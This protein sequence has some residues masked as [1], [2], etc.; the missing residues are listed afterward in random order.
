[1]SHNTPV[2]L[3]IAG[4]DPFGGAGIQADLK[5]IHAMG[6]Y[7][8]TVPT[9]LTAQNSQGVAHVQSTPIDSFVIQL[10]TLLEDIQVDAVKIGMLANVEI[11]Q[12]VAGFIQEHN[13]PNVVLDTVLVSSS[14][15]DL[16]DPNALDCLISDLLPLAT[17]ITPNLPE[18]NRIL[19]T[20]F[21]GKEQEMPTVAKAFFDLGVKSA[22]IKGGHAENTDQACDF[23]VLSDSD[24]KTFCSPRIETSHTHGT[25]C[26]F[27]S[28]IATE[29]A[30]GV[31]LVEAVEAAKHYID[32]ALRAGSQL[33]FEYLSEHSSRREPLKH[34]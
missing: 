23:L 27:S 17:V 33:Q 5:T 21:V 18:V 10:E 15:K 31:T 25:G 28:A 29:L 13:L 8:L 7:A 14:G 32:Q 16:L 6:G 24:P 1:M 22:V 2:V 26:T 30:K 20:H 11:V 3:T 9:A 34:L 4:S 19:G 12:I